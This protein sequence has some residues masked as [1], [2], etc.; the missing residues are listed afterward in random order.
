MVTFVS[1]FLWLVTGVQQVEVAVEGPVA[2]VEIYLDGRVI[3]VA[4]AP[5]WRIDCDF[6]AALRPHEMVAVARSAHGTELGRAQQVV[7][8]PRPEAEVEVVLERGPDGLPEFARVVTQSRQLLNP[9]KIM[10]TF[11]GLVLPGDNERY[12]LPDFDPE[13]VHMLSAEALFP[14]GVSARS[15]LSFGGPFSGHVVTELTAVAV[16]VDGKR[17]PTVGDFEGALRAR[18]VVVEGTAVE[19]LGGRVSLVRD[20]AAWPR[21]REIGIRMAKM[22]P[23][24]RSIQWRTIEKPTPELDR[25]ALVVPNPERK[26]ALA[27]FP[28]HGPF[29]LGRYSLPWMASQRTSKMATIEGQQLATAVAV[30]GVRAARGSC[31]RAVILLL[32]ENPDDASRYRPNDVKGFLRSLQVPLF[33]WSSSGA[34]KTAWGPAEDVSSQQMLKKASERLMKKLLR[35][36]IVWVEGRHLPGEI[37]LDQSVQGIRLAE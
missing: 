30:A 19:K 32:S 13:Q 18:G 7:N 16:E 21:M 2:A 35:Q 31:P 33:V 14:G 10:V 24:G 22:A 29:R 20:H 3:G 36:S 4:T 11:D 34:A 1:L 17:R 8:L 15:D 12:P 9:D 37:E 28:V 27:I 25:F 6:G 5:A 26:Q 23:R